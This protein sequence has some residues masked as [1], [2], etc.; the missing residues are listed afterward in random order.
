[1][2]FGCFDENHLGSELDDWDGD[3]MVHPKQGVFDRGLCKKRGVYTSDSNVIEL[4]PEKICFVNFLE[5]QKVSAQAKEALLTA[6]VDSKETLVSLLPGDIE[7]FA[8]PLGQKR[9]IQRIIKEILTGKSGTQPGSHES[10]NGL[11]GCEM[12]QLAREAHP[13]AEGSGALDTG[14]FLGFGVHGMQKP[15]HDIVDF[16]PK[17]SPY[18]P[19]DD[20]SA[21]IVQK[22]GG[23]LAVE[24][25]L[26]KEKSL[27]KISWQQW[28]EAAIQIMSV[29]MDE[30]V[31]ARDYM[32]Y[33]IIVAQLAGRYDWVSVL[34]Y[35]REYRKKQAN[36]GQKW[37]SD[38]AILREVTLLPKQTLKASLKPDSA[39]VQGKNKKWSSMDQPGSQKRTARKK[40]SQQNSSNFAHFDKY[41]VCR[42]FNEGTCSFGTTCKFKHIC[43]TCHDSTH[44]ESQHP[45]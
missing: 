3:D 29:L 38:M 7:G 2:P 41:K 31:S 6:G 37:G 33:I 43:N 18:D 16:L 44:G 14:F 22:E 1:M 32:L 30:G 15:Y 28:L 45:N 34:K 21:V 36:T 17:R 27:E 4:T 12:Q 42:M 35:V 39:S 13:Q 19:S 8:L 40:K 24:P 9:L 26:S 25:N 10:V 23:F 11:G 5:E 20:T